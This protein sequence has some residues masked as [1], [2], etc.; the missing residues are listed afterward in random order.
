MNIWNLSEH[1]SVIV[2]GAS[3]Q[4]RKLKTKIKIYIAYDIYENGK[5]KQKEVVCDSYE[6]AERLLPDVLEASKLGVVFAKPPKPEVYKSPYIKAST[7]SEDI[8][9]T[10]SEL[11]DKYVEMKCAKNWEAGTK[12]IS[13]NI[14]KHYINPFIGNA[15]VA[16]MTP[17]FIQEYISDL[18]NHPAAPGAHKNKNGTNKRI[19]ARTV[20]EVMKILRPAFG[21]ASTI[22]GVIPYNP[23]YDVSL[24]DEEEFE[25]EQWSEQEVDYA[26][27]R[28]SDHMLK[29]SIVIEYFGTLRTGEGC[30][31]TLDCIHVTDEDLKSGAARIHINKTLR[32]LNKKDLDDTRSRGILYVFPNPDN[33]KD[34][35]T[36]IV[37]KKPKTK[38]SI[39]D[40][41]MPETAA[42]VISDYI[43][44]RNEQLGEAIEA[45][46]YKQYGGYDFLFTQMNGRPYEVKE[47]RKRFK[48]FIKDNGLRPVDFYSLR[49]SGSTSKLRV[50]KGDVK[51]VQGDTGHATANTL[52]KVY[53]SIVDEDRKNIATF[54]EKKHFGENKETEDD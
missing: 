41:Y 44:Y 22:L 5:R 34:V 19:S 25:R 24:P 47:L 46:V 27:K 4:V 43:K 26:L 31:L 6:E 48:K 36:T 35:K 17:K 12:Q 50:S 33:T 51:A 40:I 45:G 23:T 14:I 8:N 37:I 53:A 9:I 28:C 2:L 15:K 3:I 13:D 7:Q 21:Y 49:H 11:L 18:P 10:V 16:G 38:K 30:A 42:I 32:R 54:M 39:R 20:K 52:L 29:A 1:R